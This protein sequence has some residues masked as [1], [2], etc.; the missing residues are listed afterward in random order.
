MGIW[1]TKT[2]GFQPR[3]KGYE[4]RTSFFLW[5]AKTKP[6]SIE[7]LPIAGMLEAQAGVRNLQKHI[8]RIC[9]K[10]ATKVVEQWEGRLGLSGLVSQNHAELLVRSRYFWQTNCSRLVVLVMLR[11]CK[12]APQSIVSSMICAAM[13]APEDYFLDFTMSSK[14]LNSNGG[15]TE[16]DASEKDTAEPSPMELRVDEA[17]LTEYVGKPVARSGWSCGWQN[18]D[19]A[20]QLQ[21]L[22]IKNHHPKGKDS[23]D[24]RILQPLNI[25]EPYSTHFSP[26]PPSPP[27]PRAGL[28]IRPAVWRQLALRHRHRLGLD[29][30]GGLRAV[31]RASKTWRKRWAKVGLRCWYY[32][33]SY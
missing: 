24:T 6:G 30:H 19:L 23:F 15:T 13:S 2:S 1:S 25:I 33:I 32:H 8:E 26:S 9:R 3:L 18:G 5:I 29:G 14:H 31:H 12:I 22:Y 21:D 20:P 17:A 11:C 28:H 4:A 7:N 27:H 16:G 10:M